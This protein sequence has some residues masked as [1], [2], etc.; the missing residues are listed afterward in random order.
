METFIKTLVGLHVVTGKDIAPTRHE[1][2][3]YGKS[4]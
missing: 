1:V 2:Q 4:K 3:H